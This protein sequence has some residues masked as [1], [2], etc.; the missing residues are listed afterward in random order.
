[1]FGEIFFYVISIA[2]FVIMFIKIM[3]KNDMINFASLILQAIGIGIKF[4]SYIINL[5]YD[6][7]IT[8]IFSSM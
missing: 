3:K 6:Y 7:N 5:F 4:V 2:L 8:N 1:M